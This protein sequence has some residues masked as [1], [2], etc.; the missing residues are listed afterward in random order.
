ML[1]STETNPFINFK[2]VSPNI[3]DTASKAL[4]PMQP[5]TPLSDMSDASNVKCD[6]P[7]LIAHYDKALESSPPMQP[8]GGEQWASGK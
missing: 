5:S 7:S 6:S 8:L 1:T 2:L 4:I 3:E